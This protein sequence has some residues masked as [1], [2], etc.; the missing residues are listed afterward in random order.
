M[1]DYHF[2]REDRNLDE[3]IRLDDINEKLKELESEPDDE[4]GDKNEFLN[5]SVDDRK[6]PG[7]YFYVGT[8]AERL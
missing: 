1:K 2:E 4:L 8:Y 6:Y 5:G 3:T 7:W